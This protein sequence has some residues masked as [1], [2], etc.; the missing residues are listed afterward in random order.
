MSVNNMNL[1]ENI[2]DIPYFDASID[3]RRYYAVPIPDGQ[4]FQLDDPREVR[5]Q[6]FYQISRLERPYIQ[7]FPTKETFYIFLLF[8][9]NV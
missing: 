2:I 3:A 5:I 8:I 6:Y 7:I 4:C 1:F 9:W